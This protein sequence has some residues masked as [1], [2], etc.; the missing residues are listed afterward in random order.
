MVLQLGW[1]LYKGSWVG[2][3]LAEEVYNHAPVVS[4]T[5]P[6]PKLSIALAQ[7]PRPVAPISRSDVGLD[8]HTGSG[9]RAGECRADGPSASTTLHVD[10]ALQVNNKQSL[11]VKSINDPTNALYGSSLTV[12]QFLA[13]YAPTAAQVQSVTNY[14]SGYG[15]SNIQVE[16]NNVFITADGTVTQ[17][18]AAFHTSIGEFSQNGSTVYANLTDAQVPSSLAG[19]VI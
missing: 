15:F 8:R 3:G 13:T 7:R 19:T 6:F 12:S 1:C 10:G 14:L 18:S 5:V 17:V 11:N 16:P 9:R 2:V 4:P